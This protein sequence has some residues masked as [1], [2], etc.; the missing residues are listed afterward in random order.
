MSMR[1][2]L[3]FCSCKKDK[4]KDQ[5]MIYGDFNQHQNEREPQ[6]QTRSKRSV[7]DRSNHEPDDGNTS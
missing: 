6:D 1:K 4:E 2:L 5:E 3:S 7:V